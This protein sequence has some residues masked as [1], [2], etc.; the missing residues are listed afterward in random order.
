MLDIWQHLWFVLSGYQQHL[1]WKPKMSPDTAKCPPPGAIVLSSL[2]TLAADFKKIIK[3]WKGDTK[4]DIHLKDQNA[5]FPSISY[6]K[7]ILI[8]L[9]H[10]LL[11]AILQPPL[12]TW[13][14]HPLI[15]DMVE[16]PSPRRDHQSWE[17]RFL[18]PNAY[19]R[20]GNP[21]AQF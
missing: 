17:F 10:C 20:D 12:I 3:I 7:S 9:I 11:I 6:F 21:I 13:G 14:V 15:S 2:D 4:V 19:S 8:D 18:L 1:L 5:C 16:S